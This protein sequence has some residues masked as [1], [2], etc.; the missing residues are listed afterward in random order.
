MAL[1]FVNRATT[2][3]AAVTSAPVVYS[4]NM[5]TRNF[6]RFF[7]LVLLAALPAR[8]ELLVLRTAA[9]DGLLAKFDAGNQERPGI[10]VEIMYA[11]QRI[12]PALRF[13]GFALNMPT[14]RI[15][16]ELH[17]GNLDIFFG[18]LRTPA[19][20][21][22]Y[23]FIEPALFA[24]KSRVAV[25]KDDAVRIGSLADVVRLGRQ[26]VILTTQGT[27]HVGFLRQTPGLLVDD[28][29]RSSQAN[30]QK[31]LQGRGRFYYQGDLNLV[32]DIRRY[33]MQEQVRLLPVVF[34]AEAQYV[35]FSRRVPPSAIERVRRALNTLWQSGELAR[36]YQRYAPDLA[37]P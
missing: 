8:A 18:F 23:H 30:L 22:R 29:A 11:L 9:Q 26:G 24:Q 13:T 14:A 10:C 20:E 27:A 28:G 5:L 21:Q 15:E 4:A 1:F 2:G 6:A 32:S 25:R 12:D 37:S 33:Q 3:S 36:I 31:L 35:V 17:N 19:R 16:D 34:R 7:L